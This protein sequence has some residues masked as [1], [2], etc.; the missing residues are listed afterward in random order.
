[1]KKIVILGILLYTNQAYAENIK[2]DF[3][4]WTRAG[5]LIESKENPF[6]LQLDQQLR[7]NDNSSKFN[8]F[9]TRIFGNYK[10]DKNIFSL[11]Y[12]LTTEDKYNINNVWALQYTNDLTFYEDFIFET[13]LRLESRWETDSSTVKTEHS[14]RG[15]TRGGIEYSLTDNFKLLVNNELFFTQNIG[16][17][18]NRVQSG[19]TYKFNDL[20]S[21][22]IFYQH[23]FLNEIEDKMEHTIFTNLLHKIEI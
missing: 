8:S 7:L 5:I 19:I 10:V 11:G 13:R 22:D 12:L 15:R 20:T 14:W 4:S 16:F 6:S 18:E 2:Q 21:I 17:S 9:Q 1:M 3:V 23:R